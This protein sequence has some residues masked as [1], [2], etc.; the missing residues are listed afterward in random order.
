MEYLIHPRVKGFQH[1]VS[2]LRNTVDAVWDISIGYPDFIP[3]TEESVFQG[4]F[5]KEVHFHFKRYAIEEI[6][7]KDEELAT[8]LQN[9]WT[10]KEQRLEAFYKEKKFPESVATTNITFSL[11]FGIIGWIV[12]TS[13][14]L[15]LLYYYPFA[16]WYF[17]IVAILYQVLTV[18]KSIDLI[19]LEYFKNKNLSTKKND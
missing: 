2:K 4:K 3:Q 16:R 13:F 5:P 17:L 11:L 14:W 7:T 1:T 9:C 18:K 6:P 10:E 15:V 8:W 19:E 12:K